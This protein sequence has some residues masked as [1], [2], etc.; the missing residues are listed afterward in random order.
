MVFVMGISR[1]QAILRNV[2]DDFIVSSGVYAIG[3]LPSNSSATR[4]STKAGRGWGLYSSR[5][6]IRHH[7]ALGTRGDIFQVKFGN[8]NDC[9]KVE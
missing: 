5:R 9:G 3:S 2:R 4:L 8:D 7:H 1:A 6:F